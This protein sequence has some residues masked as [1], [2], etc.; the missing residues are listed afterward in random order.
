MVKPYSDDLRER[1]ARFVLSGA[2]VRHGAEVFRVSVASALTWTQRYRASGTA[3]AKAMGGRRRD[4]M[5]GGRDCA[6]ARLA[7]HPS[8]ALRA[9]QAELAERG[10]VV[11][12]GAVWHFVHAEGLSFKKTVLASE[13]ERPDVARRRERWRRHQGRIDPQRLVFLDGEPSQRHRFERDGE[14]GEDQHGPPARLGT[15]RGPPARPPSAWPLAHADRPRRAARRP[16]RRAVPVQ[17]RAMGTPPVRVTM[18]RDQRREL[19]RLGQ[20]GAGPHALPRRHRR[21]GQSRQ[22]QGKGRPLCDP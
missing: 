16:H 19:H 15:A 22:P 5:A 10:V 6:L 4:V 1:V 8:L 12:Y 13:I 9:L 17:C 2:T 21:A 14:R 18:A 3:A 20:A 7:E 11:S